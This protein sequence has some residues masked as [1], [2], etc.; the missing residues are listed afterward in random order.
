MN[1]EL[2]LILKI[3]HKQIFSSMQERNINNEVSY[4]TWYRY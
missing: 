3:T 2:K 4:R 1:E